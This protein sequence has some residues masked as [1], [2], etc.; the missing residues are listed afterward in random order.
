MTGRRMYVTINV[1]KQRSWRHFMIHRPY[2]KTYEL[3]VSWLF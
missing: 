2:I 3:G 1:C